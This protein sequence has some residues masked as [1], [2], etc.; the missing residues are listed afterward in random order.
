MWQA[1]LPEGQTEPTEEWLRDLFWLLTQGHI[2]LL[3]DDS[4]V[5]PVRRPRSEPAAG[6]GTEAPAPKKKR[7]RNRKRRGRPLA[8]VKGKLAELR[9]SKPVAK[10][11][12]RVVSRKPIV[13][14]APAE[15]A[16]P[17]A[18]AAEVPVAHEV[19]ASPAVHVEV[20][21]PPTAV[22]AVVPE[23]AIETPE[24]EA[25]VPQAVEAGEAELVAED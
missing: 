17:E 6:D 3:Q 12:L 22:A 23:V 8:G 14:P 24:V 7:K 18:Q 11:N 9:K 16:E 20:I 2:L 13:R 5:L 1:V 19:P 10:R 4:L 15:V 21:V 25:A